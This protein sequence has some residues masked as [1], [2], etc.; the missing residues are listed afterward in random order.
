MA[1]ENKVGV[2]VGVSVTGQQDLGAL[3]QQID[4]T[5]Q[6]AQQLGQQ[7]QAAGAGLN[8]AAASAQGAAQGLAQ[9]GDAA[10]QAGDKLG[11]T[12]QGL[13]S[14]S[15]QLDELQ[16]K[17]QS[18]AKDLTSS[19]GGLFAAA[20]LK[21]YAQ[22]IITV[23]DAYGQ[24]AERIKMATPEA[25]EFDMVQRRILESAN[26]TYRP[27]AEQQELYIRT[28]DALRSL[29]YNTSEALDITDSFSYLLTT[30]AASGERAA[31]A[32]SAYAKSIQSG[33]VDALSWQSMLAATPT[34]VDAIASATGRTTAE[35]RQMGITGSLTVRDLNEGLRQSVDVNKQ[36]ASQMSATVTDAVTRLANTWQVY[37][38]EAN[39]ASGATRNIVTLLDTLSANLDTV[40][41]VAVKLGEAVVAALGMRALGALK[42]YVAQQVLA[43]EAT[44][45]GARAAQAQ[46]AALGAG[47]VAAQRHTAAINTNTA[48][49]A[50]NAVAARASSAATAQQAVAHQAAAAGMGVTGSAVTGVASKLGGLATAARLAGRA[51]LPLAALDFALNFREYGKWIGEA[52]AKLM[53]YKD[54]SEE[55]A[56]QWKINEEIVNQSIQAR[57]ELA[58]KIQ[59]AIDKQFELSA[60]AKDAVGKF[61]EL[62][63][64]GDKASEAVGK[65]V[66]SFDL[67]KFDGIK[68]FSATL[69]K[70]AADGKLAANEFQDA[71]AQALDG[72]DLLQFETMARTAFAG[73]AREADRLAQ[74]M[75]ATLRE[76]V[77]RTGLDYDVL[78]GKIGAAARSAINDTDRIIGGLD[79]LKAQGVDTGQVLATSISN[80]IANADSQQAIES[81]RAQIESVRD[82][83]GKE[84]TNGLLD[85]AK[86]KSDA[87]A[88][89]L[90]RATPGINSVREAMSKLGVTSEATLSKAAEDAKKAYEKIES[91]G[92]ASTRE[93]QAAFKKAADAAIDAADGV[94]PEWVRMKAAARGYRL[95]VDQSGQ[96]HLKLGEKARTGADEVAAAFARMGVKT[97][98]QLTEAA[99]QAQK[100]FTTIQMSGQA[101]AEQLQ[102][103]FRRYAEASIAANNGVADES[104]RAEAAQHGLVIAID[105]TGKAVVRTAE[106][107]ERA[108]NRVA[109][110]WDK[111]SSSIDK[112]GKAQERFSKAGKR[113]GEGVQE[114]GDGQ[115]R[116][117]DKWASDESGK[118]MSFG[119]NESSFNQ[120]IARNFGEQFIGNQAAMKAA[121]LKMN[122]DY[123]DNL[124][125]KDIDGSMGDMRREL[126]RLKREMDKQREQDRLAR[127]Q[128]PESA[129]G[130]GAEPNTP[131]Q[132]GAG[133]GASKSTGATY[134]NN[135]TL[136]GKKHSVTT[137]DAS[138]QQALEQLLRQLADD[139]A[140][141]A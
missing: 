65:I 81:V 10:E 119:M 40:V 41:T 124:G 9:T 30:N 25:A 136:A 31:N 67:T 87:L 78:Q 90:D 2:E 134:V 18:T 137:A 22:D 13:K 114:I 46:S 17:L 35:I 115:F 50:A 118:A 113:L 127:Q 42:S 101:T 43:A 138:S 57:R 38:G 71:W 140:R 86:E 19:I 36:A 12:R 55:L 4:Q 64:A 61:D 92:T 99:R 70:L 94:A 129:G 104:I 80:A 68:D 75:D 108:T 112:A 125:L 47:A 132:A 28:A 82:V 96:A 126:E 106:E 29:K 60:A 73:S 23:A 8:A 16:G 97:Q 109:K 62:T 58:R 93:L 131:P 102:I 14:I 11:A 7:G 111:V 33:K 21:G 84:V 116:N 48:A 63:K 34:I 44:A 77:K 49:L 123:W 89:A 120:Y 74:L 100:D 88:D 51:F 76:A 1:V 59:E 117:A 32:I 26:L 85:Q 6:H 37:I 105:E 110:G 83:L 66:K 24:M 122:L 72:K 107:M 79:Q 56:R 141:S 15:T 133:A 139:K 69:D 135:I 20:K 128:K 52:A 53:G 121:N 130:D 95:E 103:A 3:G 27:L 98:A 39:K 45:S 5:G 91:S 54:R